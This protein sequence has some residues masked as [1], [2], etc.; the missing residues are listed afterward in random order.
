MKKILIVEDSYIVALHLQATLENEGYLIVGKCTSGEEALLF[1]ESNLPDLVLMDI[2]LE[3]AMD[4]IE[5]AE[6]IKEKYNL[7]VI[8]ITALSDRDTIARAKLTEPY[9]FLTKPFED[10]EIFTVI[11]M[12]LYKHSMETKLWQSEE[13]Y[14][15]TLKSISDAVIVIDTNF[16]ITFINPSAQALTQFAV[17]QTVGRSIF[18]ILKLKDSITG[19]FP[20][21]PLQCPLGVTNQ[22]SLPQNALLVN[23]S[24]KELPIGES[25]L[26]LLLDG[27]ERLN[28]LVIT[29][30]DV[31]EKLEKEAMLKRIEKVKVLSLI[32]GQEKER[33]RI[34]QDLHDGLGQM[35]NA[36]KINANAIIGSEKLNDHFFQM[37][38]EA[39][40]ECIRIS[41]N[42]L[43][44]KLNNFDL[45]TC[46]RSLCQQLNKNSSIEISYTD[47][48]LKFDIDQSKKINLYRI[49]QEAI[50]NSIKHARA[51]HVSVQLVQHGDMLHLSI[52][53][54]GVGLQQ[55]C[56]PEVFGKNGLAN[57]RDRVDMI[58]GKLTIESAE[59]KGTLLVIEFSP[60]PMTSYAEV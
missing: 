60:E 17:A 5:V 55:L 1:L 4:G 57:I 16:Q 40:Q 15:S 18:D 33:R 30:R 45:S 29:F 21:N 47:T 51:K 12:A 44:S 58:N 50:N 53:D 26:S 3:G 38:D 39:I 49:T 27:K 54:D 37:I 20:I 19:A 28:G 25:T 41:E 36:I 10:R 24:G 2:M 46:L 43:P 32:E 56:N 11:D 6:L 14:F 42:L 52:E 7:P 8:Y 59:G 9:G 22:T 35:L 23:A 31:S 34:A 13:K 48:H